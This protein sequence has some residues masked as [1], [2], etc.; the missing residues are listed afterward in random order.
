MKVGDL[1]RWEG[2]KNDSQK[3]LDID[4]GVIIEL[5]EDRDPKCKKE[6]IYKALIQFHDEIVWL[7]VSCITTI[8]EQS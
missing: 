2:V 4:Y 8:N 1:V 3:E 7:P 6:D 5:R